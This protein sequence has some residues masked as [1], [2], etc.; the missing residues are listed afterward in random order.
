M[1][2]KHSFHYYISYYLFFYSR[3]W[4][5]DT[6]RESPL[7]QILRWITGNRLFLYLEECPDFVFN[8]EEMK[9]RSEA[10]QSVDNGFTRS[11]ANGSSQDLSWLPAH[12]RFYPPHAQGVVTTYIVDWYGPDDPLN[13]KNWSSLKK[14]AVA[15]QIWCDFSAFFSSKSIVF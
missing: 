10:A 8:P 13:P 14:K 6:V 5:M 1:D 4:N 15:F 12:A 3:L 11:E 9:Q 7:G 2:F